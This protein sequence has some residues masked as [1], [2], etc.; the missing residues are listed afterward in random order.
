MQ[1]RITFPIVSI[2]FNIG[3]T[4]KSISRCKCIHIHMYTVFFYKIQRTEWIHLLDTDW[5]KN[6]KKP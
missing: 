6:N 2:G 4:K 5:T 3:S 1:Q